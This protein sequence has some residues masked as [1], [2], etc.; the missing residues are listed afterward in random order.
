MKWILIVLG[1]LLGLLLLSAVVLFAMG[2]SADANRMTNSIVIHQKPG[3]VWPWLYKPEKVKQWV[4]WL[5]EIREER[6]GEPYVGGR[7]V[8]VM[9]DRNNN[10]ARMEITGVV[11]AVYPDRRIEVGLSAPEG[12]RGTNTYTLTPLADGSTR[13]DSDARYDFD[14][15]FAHFMTP[16]ICWQAKKKM[17]EDM[18]HLKSLVENAK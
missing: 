16:V 17:N 15:A 2:T 1:S 9:E 12:F 10:N 11:K 18:G 8:W 6:S 7:A 3:A 5:V 13:L 4:S 14:N